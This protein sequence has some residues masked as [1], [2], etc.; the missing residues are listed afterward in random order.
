M[1][2][3]NLKL[4]SEA[5]D[6]LF[7]DLLN[8]NLEN[9]LSVKHLENVLSVSNQSK[10]FCD[11]DFEHDMKTAEAIQQLMAYCTQPLQ[12]SQW[13]DQT[14]IPLAT[15]YKECYENSKEKKVEELLPCPFCGGEAELHT[16]DFHNTEAYIL[17]GD[18]N[19]RTDTVCGDTE[20]STKTLII[21][22]WN[23]RA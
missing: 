17:C 15:A 16:L 20:S 19:A 18:C 22:D 14:Y 5:I 8:E 23:T 4:S 11:E 2:T 9:V 3:V 13:V 7:I 21:E 1:T 6:A 12:F 10:Y